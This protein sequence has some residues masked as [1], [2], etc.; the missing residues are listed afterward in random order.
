MQVLP[1]IVA[2]AAVGF[3]VGGCAT[4][5][6]QPPTPPQTRPYV[7][8]YLVAGERRSEWNDAERAA[9]Q[10]RH[11]GRIRELVDEGVLLVAGPFG[12]DNH[13]PSVR[14]L[15]VFDVPSLAEAERLTSTDPAIEAGVLAMRLHRFETD[16]DLRAA[17]AAD[18]AAEAEAKREGRELR[19]Q[20]RI[21]AYGL[22][23]TAEARGCAAACALLPD[24]D[25][26]ILTA[27]V[28][29]RAGLCVIRTDDLPRL[30]ERLSESSASIGS[31]TLDEWWASAYLDRAMRSGKT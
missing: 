2:V 5:V 17:V 18:L 19:M 24:E 15:F 27:T 20:D 13:D 10:E 25:R 9:I 29:G 22:L 12:R 11:M 1:L 21:R 28:D 6:E 14:G 4:R 26:A 31:Y 7:L 8:V 3:L 16:A 23:R 30:R